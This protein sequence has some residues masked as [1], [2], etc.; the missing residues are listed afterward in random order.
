MYEIKHTCTIEGRVRI[1]VRSQFF[2]G[3]GWVGF[4]ENQNAS[5]LVWAGFGLLSYPQ[6]SGWL[7]VVQV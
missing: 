5:D 1:W 6:F 4:E 2:W 3:L 7:W